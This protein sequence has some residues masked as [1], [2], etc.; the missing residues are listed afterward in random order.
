M[1]FLTLQEKDKHIVSQLQT[2]TNVEFV[3]K[4]NKAWPQ[5]IVFCK[6]GGFLFVPNSEKASN[7]NEKSYYANRSLTMEAGMR[8]DEIGYYK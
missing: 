6:K 2:V 7:F 5:N 4:F 1:C 3:L 8:H